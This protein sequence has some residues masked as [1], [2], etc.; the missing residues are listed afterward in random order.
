MTGTEGMIGVASLFDPEASVPHAIVQIPGAALRMPVAAC[1]SAFEESAAVRRA[2]LRFA[3]SQ[4][5]LRHPNR[6]PQSNT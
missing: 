4:L 1:R 6:C 5:A 2:M 3:S